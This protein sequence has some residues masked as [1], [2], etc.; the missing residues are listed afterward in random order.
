[1]EGFGVAK[2]VFGANGQ[3]RIPQECGWRN[4]ITAIAP[5]RPKKGPLRFCCSIELE[6]GQLQLPSLV[7]QGFGAIS[8]DAQAIE[9]LHVT[10]PIP[11]CIVSP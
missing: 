9:F 11:L 1:M 6:F 3:P 7:G 10:L 5:Q 8:A 2:G 4:F